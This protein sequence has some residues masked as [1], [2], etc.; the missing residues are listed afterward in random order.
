MNSAKRRHMIKEQ[1]REYRREF[2]TDVFGWCT[3]ASLSYLM[4]VGFFWILSNPMSTWF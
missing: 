2:L 3:I 1:E 4:W